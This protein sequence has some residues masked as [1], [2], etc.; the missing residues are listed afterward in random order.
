MAM[1][2]NKRQMT[3]IGMM[4]GSSMDGL[5]V[6]EVSFEWLDDDVNSVVWSADGGECIAYEKPL[7]KK[8]RQAHEFSALDVLTIDIDYAKWCVKAALHCLG[9]AELIGFHG[10]TIF[11][12]PN[13]GFSRQLGH[14]AVLA[15]GWQRPV[16]V[17]FRSNDI[18]VGGKGAPMVSISEKY[19]WPGYDAY[20]NLGGICNISWFDAGEL[21]GSYDIGPCNQLLNHIANQADQS[22]D[23]GGAIGADGRVHHSL[24]N[25]W[26]NNAYYLKPISEKS[27]DNGWVRKEVLSILKNYNHLSVMDGMRTAQQLIAELIHEA[28]FQISQNLNKSR[29]KVMVSGGGVH[30]TF[31]MS[32]IR[33]NDSIDVCIPEPL[34]I[35]Y[36]EAIMIAH[37]AWLRYLNLPN[38]L[39]L[40]QKPPVSG[41]AIYSSIQT[42]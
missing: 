27:L 7:L 39:P 25:E 16:V 12:F 4:A 35:D 37:A 17:D 28:C 5:D 30:N 15:E 42:R 29:I 8:I 22:Y 26:R 13:R 6:V 32:L 31:L 19:L 9:K 36:K 18:A 40:D 33:S 41:G 23:K 14:G 10:H 11:H 34:V 3:V 21:K 20:I 38:F 1:A 24:L 2:K